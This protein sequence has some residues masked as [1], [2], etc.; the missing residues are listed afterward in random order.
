MIRSCCISHLSIFFIMVF[1]FLGFEPQHGEVTVIEYS[2]NQRNFKIIKKKGWREL[3]LPRLMV[4]HSLMFTCQRYLR[5]DFN[6]QNA[7]L[8][9][10]SLTYGDH[11]PMQQEIIY[12]CNR[13]SE[14]LIISLLAKG[15]VNH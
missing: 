5:R 9:E 11:H 4:D 10:C 6:K 14:S 7:K 2:T 12:K 15:H 1:Y 3:T 8:R 13:K